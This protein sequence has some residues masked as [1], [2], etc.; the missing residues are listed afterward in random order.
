MEVV[1]VGEILVVLRPPK[2][3]I[4]ETARLLEILVGGSEANVLA[5]LAR[6]GHTVG[7]ITRVPDNPL[8]R[9]AIA[10]YRSAG[11]DMSR[12]LWSS[13]GKMG[14]AFVELSTPP[15]KNRFIYDRSLSEASK[16]SKDDIDYDYVR[17][18]KVLHLSGITPALSKSCAEVVRILVEFAKRNGLTV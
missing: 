1:A 17:K 7:L 12:V 15:R 8:G 18:A 6:L 2:Y 11:V 5:G 10:K 14:L 4:L 3:H 9:L 16:L 13:D